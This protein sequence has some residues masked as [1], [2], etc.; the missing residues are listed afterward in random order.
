MIFNP[1]TFI[2]QIILGYVLLCVGLQT[3]SFYQTA[4]GV[5]QAFAKVSQVQSGLE[6]LNPFD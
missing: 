4:Q 5:S 2:K 6:R 1:L 3:W